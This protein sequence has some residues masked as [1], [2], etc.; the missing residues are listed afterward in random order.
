MMKG[1]LTNFFVFG[2]YTFKERDAC[3]LAIR[4]GTP[5]H[6]LG[7]GVKLPHYN[8]R[9]GPYKKIHFWHFHYA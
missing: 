4:F 1:H 5:E 7:D 3:N 2:V 8:I 9:Y 6:D